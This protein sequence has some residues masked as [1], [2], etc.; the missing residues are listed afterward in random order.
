MLYVNYMSIKLEKHS[1][2]CFNF[3]HFFKQLDVAG[4]IE[5]REIQEESSPSLFADHPVTSVNDS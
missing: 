2:H 3:K 5:E 4:E 1:L